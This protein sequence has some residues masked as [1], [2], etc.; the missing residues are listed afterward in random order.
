VSNQTIISDVNGAETLLSE[1]YFDRDRT[2]FNINPY[3][4]Y[5]SETDKLVID[6]NY[7]DFTDTSTN[8]FLMLQEAL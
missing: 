6:F 5:Q 4:E 1:N 3:Y 7:V 8:T 2:D